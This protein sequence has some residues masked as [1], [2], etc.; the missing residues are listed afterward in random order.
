[1]GRDS[2]SGAGAMSISGWHDTPGLVSDVQAA[3]FADG[4]LA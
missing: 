4:L 2:R 1:M 3:A